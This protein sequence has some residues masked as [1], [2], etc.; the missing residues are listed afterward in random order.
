MI[1]SKMIFGVTTS[2]NQLN[3]NNI[4]MEIKQFCSTCFDDWNN[5]E[6]TSPLL[7]ICKEI[8][9]NYTFDSFTEL[10]SSIKSS[11]TFKCAY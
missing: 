11:T 9:E 5:N 6:F 7:K 2:S 4:K 1:K 10:F 8:V 3:N